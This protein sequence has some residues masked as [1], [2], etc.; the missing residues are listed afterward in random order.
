MKY[1]VPREKTTKYL[2]ANPKKSGFFLPF[3]YTTA[4]WMRLHD[5]LL[6][7]A[8]KFPRHVRQITKHGTEYEIIGFITAPN[9]R[10]VAIRTGWILLNGDP[11]TLRFLTA[12][13]A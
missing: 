8:D 6:D 13:P 3:G 9:G 5:D 1:V 7:I 2:L 11:G 10:T 12:Y 4:N